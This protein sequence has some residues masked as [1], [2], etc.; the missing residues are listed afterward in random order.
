M[1]DED[2]D[3]P[4]DDV[5]ACREAGRGGLNAVAQ[6]DEKIDNNLNNL[7]NKRAEPH[8]IVYQRQASIS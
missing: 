8:N 3:E 6:K 1:A 2:E 5:D 4:A 7:E